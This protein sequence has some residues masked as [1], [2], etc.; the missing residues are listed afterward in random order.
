MVIFY[1]YLIFGGLLLVSIPV[2]CAAPRLLG[3]WCGGA[4][5]LLTFTV[6]SW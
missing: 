2:V 5:L 4:L 1:V 6:L 3:F